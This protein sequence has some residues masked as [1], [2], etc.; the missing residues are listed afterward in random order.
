MHPAFREPM[1]RDSKR[2]F[3]EKTRTAFLRQEHR[4]AAN[5]PA[6][7]VTL[8]VSRPLDDDPIDRLAQLEGRPTPRGPHVVAEVGGTVA[9]A[10]SFEPGPPL[11][12]PFRPTAHLIPLT[13]TQGETAH[14]RSPMAM[15]TGRLAPELGRCPVEAPELTLS[16]PNPDTTGSTSRLLHL[17]RRTAPPQAQRKEEKSCTKHAVSPNRL[18]APDVVPSTTQSLPL[19]HPAHPRRTRQSSHR[20]GDARPIRSE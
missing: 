16:T 11:V 1:L 6:E 17:P 2:R 12:D 20:A 3:E 14:P 4:P 9:A 13:R 19:P 7:S 10:L 18:R 15:D 8:R 5:P